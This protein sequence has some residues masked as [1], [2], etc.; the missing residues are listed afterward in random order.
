MRAWIV[1]DIAQNRRRQHVVR[2]CRDFGLIRAQKSVF[3][4]VIE[5]DRLGYFQNLLQQEIEADEDSL[6]ILPTN[7]RLIEGGKY[8]GLGFDKALAM[9]ETEVLFL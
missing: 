2:I 1:Y 8:L 9:R 3:V 7:K 6:F 5:D 4:G